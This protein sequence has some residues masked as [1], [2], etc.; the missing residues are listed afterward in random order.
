[1][2]NTASGEPVK[3]RIGV[4]GCGTAGP[5]AATLLARQGHQVEL[6]ERAPECRAVGAGFLLQPSGMTVLR[7]L[8]IEDEVLSHAAKVDRLHIVEPS[9]ETLL[10]LHYGEIGEGWFGCGLHRPVLLHHLIRAMEDAGVLMKWDWEAIS[11]ERENDGWKL[12]S[13]KGEVRGGFDLLIIC[14]GARSKLRDLV[15]GSNR[16]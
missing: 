13:A 2:G 1:M 9:G 14:D 4:V 10:D 11:A 8:G 7:E 3:L 15:G 16:G 6:F 5:V 12:T